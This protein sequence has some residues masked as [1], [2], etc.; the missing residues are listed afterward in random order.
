MVTVVVE[1]G[2]KSKI[3]LPDGTLV[4]LNSSTKLM[5][6]VEAGGKRDV[7]I[8]YGEAYFD[9]TKDAEHPFRVTA[10]D[11]QIEVLGTTFNMKTTPNTIETALFS[12]RVRVTGEKMGH[13]IT[14]NPG[15]KVIYARNTHKVTVE[16]NNA[17]SDARWKDGYLVFD[18][19][20]L[21]SVFEDIEKWYGVT[22]IFSNKPMENDI[23]TGS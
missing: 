17:Y 12:G 5:Y 8:C 21:S 20:P 11:T 10:A 7:Q 23:L 22:I 9:V 18:S 19:A 4:M 6:D 14:L 13:E 15:K 2:N 3:T 16:D 1:P